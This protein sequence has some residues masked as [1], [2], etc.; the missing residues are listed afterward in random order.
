MVLYHNC[1][2]RN[3]VIQVQDARIADNYTY[4]ATSQGC[5]NPN[6]SVGLLQW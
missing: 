1:Q 6:D 3:D 2:P 4:T 5:S